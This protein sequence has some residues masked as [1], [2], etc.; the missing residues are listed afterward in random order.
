MKGDRNVRRI[1]ILVFILILYFLKNFL[2]LYY[3]IF[4]D[5]KNKNK[6]HI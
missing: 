1:L 5:K 2:Q 4:L 3:R 6:E